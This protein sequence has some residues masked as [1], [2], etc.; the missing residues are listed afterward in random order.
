MNYDFYSGLQQLHMTDLLMLIGLIVGK[1]INCD[2]KK[3]RFVSKKDVQNGSGLIGKLLG[4]PGGK[5]PVLS[6]IPLVGALF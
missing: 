1:C 6:S 2:T 5:V 4:L 3:Y